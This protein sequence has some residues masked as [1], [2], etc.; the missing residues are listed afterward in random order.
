MLTHLPRLPFRAAFAY[1][2]GMSPC[3]P[4]P[5]RFRAVLD[6]HARGSAGALP[7]RLPFRPSLNPSHSAPLTFSILPFPFKRSLYKNNTED[8]FDEEIYQGIKAPDKLF[9]KKNN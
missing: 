2:M 8:W 9:K 4:V 5:P 3:L 7:C 1:A 6:F